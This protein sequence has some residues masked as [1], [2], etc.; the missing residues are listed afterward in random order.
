MSE[1]SKPA[2]GAERDELDFECTVADA[3]EK[4]WR[5]LTTPELL[6]AWLLPNDLVAERGSRFTFD[7][8]P[9]AG[10]GI[11]C[12]V[13]DVEPHRS[14]RYS[15]R[16]RE[17]RQNGLDSIVGFKLTRT[18]DGGTHLRI[19]HEARVLVSARPKTVAAANSNRP[20]SLMLAA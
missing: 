5:A 18:A 16:D 13:L 6:A 11:D 19:S 12:E 8:G 7:D 14:I 10:G 1:D 2:S 9:G 3:P 20:A 4:V 15:W 17:A